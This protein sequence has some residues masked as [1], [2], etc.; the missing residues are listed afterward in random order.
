MVIHEPFSM[1]GL[2][3]V[4]WCLCGRAAGLVQV[5]GGA[6]SLQDVYDAVRVQ[7][8]TIAHGRCDVVRNEHARRAGVRMVLD[9]DLI[10]QG[11]L[12]SGVVK[13]DSSNQ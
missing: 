2:T 3:R 4:R 8:D 13:P 12:R 1:A 11:V 9:L 10:A 5:G 7:K 6:S